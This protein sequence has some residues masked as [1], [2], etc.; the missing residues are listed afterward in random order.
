MTER[1]RGVLVSVHFGPF[2][3]RAFGGVLPRF[4]LKRA[5]EERPL[6]FFFF[7]PPGCSRFV[8]SQ[9]AVGAGFRTCHTGVV[10]RASNRAGVFV[11][12]V[13]VREQA[14]FRSVLRRTAFRERS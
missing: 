8:L 1:A 11:E 6:L 5:L 12:R 3:G 4:R 10:S 7:L 2:F 9:T 14:R 13:T